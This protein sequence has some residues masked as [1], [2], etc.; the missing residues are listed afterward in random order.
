MCKFVT[1]SMLEFYLIDRSGFTNPKNTWNPIFYQILIQ[2]DLTF[3]PELYSFFH[4]SFK[5]DVI[6]GKMSDHFVSKFDEK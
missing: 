5:T 1:K 3:C 4:I 6:Q 2:N